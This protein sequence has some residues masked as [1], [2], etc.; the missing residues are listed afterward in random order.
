VGIFENS[1]LRRI[2]GH[3]REEVTGVWSKLHS[4]ELHDVHNK[5]LLDM[6]SSPNVVCIITE[7][8]M[9]GACDTHGGGEKSIR[10]SG[11]KTR[12]KRVSLNWEDNIKIDFKER[13]VRVWTGFFWSSSCGQGNIPTGSV[14]YD[15][16]EYLG[17]LR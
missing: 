14:N 7:R 1:V 8:E 4:E 15:N 16:L 6:H 17:L 5:K 3:K 11:G 13:D 10:G 12:R 9:G 2:F